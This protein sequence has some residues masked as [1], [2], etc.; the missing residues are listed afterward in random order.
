MAGPGGYG[1]YKDDPR[2][3]GCPRARSDMTPC[4]ARDGA[5][6][7]DDLGSCVGCGRQPHGLGG[8]LQDLR[9]EVTGDSP[10]PV[11]LP[12]H[13]ANKLKALVWQVTEPASPP[14][15]LC[16][17][18]GAEVDQVP[19]MKGCPACGCARHVPAALGDSVT[20]SITTHELRILTMWA[21]NWARSISRDDPHIGSV[22]GT[23]LER[24]GQQT[25]AALTL[26]QEL[27]DVREAFPDA[28]VVVVEDGRETDL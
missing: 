11:T 21:S 1:R 8:L 16:L 19:D 26:S 4:I 13:A 5:I 6:A 3:V 2:F 20:V 23:I 10:A 9:H 7:L 28:R 22:V 17:C 18:C 15:L 24:L 12:D 14:R 25:S 27:A